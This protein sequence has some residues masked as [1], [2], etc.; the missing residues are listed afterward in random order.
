MPKEGE[1]SCTMCT[2]RAYYNKTTG[3]YSELCTKHYGESINKD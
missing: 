1:P 3:E 2:R